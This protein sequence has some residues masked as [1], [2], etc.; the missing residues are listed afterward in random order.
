MVDASGIGQNYW[1][2]YGTMT[3]LEFTLSVQ[4]ISTGIV[5]TYSKDLTGNPSKASGQFDTSGFAP[6]PTPGSVTEIRIDTKAWEFSPGG[7]NAPPLVLHGR[8]Q[9]SPP[10]PQRGRVRRYGTQPRVHGHLRPRALR[11]ARGDDLSGAG[12]RDGGLYPP[13]LP[14]R[15]LSVPVH[16][17]QLRRR[18][19]AARVDDGDSGGAVAATIG[20]A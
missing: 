18:P 16:E 15:D 2:F 8:E 6:T 17:Q 14:A 5:K 9:L 4:E 12:L 19:T 10:V 7:A 3:D 1:V 11:L 20:S 13:A